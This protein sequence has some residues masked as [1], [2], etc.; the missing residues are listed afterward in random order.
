MKFV[1]IQENIQDFTKPIYNQE[2]NVGYMHM[3][4]SVDLNQLKELSGSNDKTVLDAMFSEQSDI[5]EEEK[6]F[7]ER[8]ISGKYEDDEDSNYLYGYALKALCEHLGEQILS[9]VADIRA[10]PYKS[11]LL[12]NKIPIDLP[13]STDFPQI[14]HLKPDEISSE[15]ELVKKTPPKPKKSLVNAILRKLTSGILGREMDAEDL[16]EDMNAYAET[17]EQALAK[18]QGL[19]SFRH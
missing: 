7:V 12:E 14:G 15:L 18:K 10:H 16:A 3:F 8:I 19:V 4:Y 11:K 13:P 1:D 9:D 17:L 5:D 2:M 6:E